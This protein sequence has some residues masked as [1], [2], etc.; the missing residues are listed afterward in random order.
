[1]EEIP[2]PKSKAQGQKTS[3]SSAPKRSQ[4]AKPRSTTVRREENDAPK[5]PLS[6]GKGKAKA[7]DEEQEGDDVEE[8]S[9]P[10]RKGKRKKDDVQ[11]EEDEEVSGK[12]NK[13]AR[14][15]VRETKPANRQRG[16]R[17]ATVQ[18]IEMPEKDEEPVKKKKRAINIFPSNAA[19]TSF[20]F[21]SVCRV[22]FFV[23][24]VVITRD[25]CPLRRLTPLAE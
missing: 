19:P 20:D 24:S 6:K 21:F 25:F 5:A 22:S 9:A 3:A 23:S 13:R 16:P 2:A 15:Q 11:A 8:G 12:G 7:R 14:S 1:M 18:P 10:K 17:S 4:P